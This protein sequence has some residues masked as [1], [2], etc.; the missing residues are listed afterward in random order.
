MVM[1]DSDGLWFRMVDNRWMD[2]RGLTLTFQKT[3]KSMGF[4]SIIRR[5]SD[6]VFWKRQLGD[7]DWDWGC[8]HCHY[9][10]YSIIGLFGW[11]L[12]DG[13]TTEDLRWTMDVVKRRIF[14]TAE[15]VPPH[16][17]GGIEYIDASR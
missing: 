5:E 1:T 13:R 12:K 3:D 15:P 4:W 16:S 6:I 8:C 17:G 10:F 14:G 7:G 11:G 9:D 2:G